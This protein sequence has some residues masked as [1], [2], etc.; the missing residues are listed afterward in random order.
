MTSVLICVAF[1][2]AFDE[3]PATNTSDS[4][5][6]DTSAASGTGR[7]EYL[8]LR[9][10]SADTADAHWKLG[11]WCE[12]KGLLAEAQVEFEA[13]VQIDPRREA[14]WRKLGYV[15]YQGHWMKLEQVAQLKAEIEA[16]RKADALWRPLLQKWKIALKQKTKRS[17]AEASLAAVTDERAVPSIWNVF[18]LGTAEDQERAVDMLG[19]IETSRS[20]RALAAVAIFGKTDLVRRAAVETVKARKGDDVLFAWI[21]LLRPTIKYEVRQVA[22]P[23]MPGVLF[24]EGDQFNVRRLYSP[25]TDQEVKG[26]LLAGP[27]PQ[28]YERPALFQSRTP[29]GLGPPEGSKCIGAVGDTALF[30]Y[31]YTWAPPPPPPGPTKG[32]QQFEQS[33]LQAQID[34]DFALEETAKMAA[35]AQAQLQNDVGVVEQANATIRERNARLSE[36]LT[37]VAGVDLGEDRERWLKWWMERKGY[38]YIAPEKRER[39]V[40]NV[41]VPLP[42]VPQSGPEVITQGGAGP[43]PKYCMLYEHDKGSLPLWGKCFGSGTTVLTPTG[44]RPIE[45]LKAGE[46]VMGSDDEICGLSAVAVAAVH[47]SSALRTLRLKIGAEVIVTTD[48]HPFLRAEST[49]ARA[50]DLKPGDWVITRTGRARVQ[51][52]EIG[53]GAPV[54]N[55]QLAGA[56][57]FLVGTAGVV[58]HD[59]SPIDDHAAE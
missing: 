33:V 51:S 53:P 12:R 20:S 49:W 40:V 41:Q 6:A 10:K 36:A 57:R 55:L 15:H 13:V 21:A 4:K 42:Y 3:P 43:Q 54:W 58:V 26:A 48:G 44:P 28:S 29:H 7:A 31:D 35:G 52:T 2:A 14:A 16:Q 39:A 59:L 8:A 46:L 56:C 1:I 19:H 47:L 11:Q 45:A 23:G 32:Y 27:S 34:R 37:Q 30:V 5:V 50:G 38:T 24:V 25:P 22:G 18:A 9:A 17:E